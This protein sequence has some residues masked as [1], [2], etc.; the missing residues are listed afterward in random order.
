[1]SARSPRAPRQSDAGARSPRG[2]PGP[3][4]RP[5]RAGC[6]AWPLCGRGCRDGSARSRPGRC[7]D[8]CLPF[9][10]LCKWKR[11]SGV[12]LCPTSRLEE[13][14]EASRGGGTACL[15]PPGARVR[16]APAPSCSVFVLFCFVSFFNHCF[17][18]PAPFVLSCSLTLVSVTVVLGPGVPFRGAH[19]QRGSHAQTCCARWGVC[20]G[21]DGQRPVVSRRA[22][23]GRLS[24]A[25]FFPP[26]V[27][28]F[29]DNSRPTG[30]EVVSH[31]VLICI[32]LTISDV[33]HLSRGNRGPEVTRLMP[34]RALKSWY[35]VTRGRRLP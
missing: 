11:G 8:V 13:P 35:G 2:G 34:K 28:R 31:L 6:G 32:S 18:E 20:P 19:R 15:Q 24:V 5:P 16:P 33:E 7:P 12:A 26:P 23:R 25:M 21:S 30:C 1:M 17:K 22:I 29:F 14:P 27:F 3:L 10:W 4:A 9:L